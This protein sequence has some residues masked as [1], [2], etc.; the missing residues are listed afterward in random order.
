MPHTTHQLLVFGEILWDMLP[1]GP[2]PGGAPANVA[3]QTHACGV[4]TLLVTAVGDDDPGR[5]M[6]AHLRERD[7]SADGVQIIPGVPTGSVEVTLKGKGMPDYCIHTG[8]AWDQIALTPA[9]RAAAQ[10]ARAI[11]FGSLAQRSPVSRDTLRALLKLAPPGCQRFFDVNL[12]RPWFDLEVIQTSLSHTDILKLNDEELPVIAD[13]LKL[14][15][16]ADAF[17]LAL[18]GKHPVHT[19]LMTMGSRGAA[20]FARDMLHPIH[21]PAAPVEKI[22]DTVGA[23]DAFS[24][25]YLAATLAGRLPESAARSGSA[26]ASRICAVSGAWLPPGELITL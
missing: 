1:S 2:Q 22:A 19:M 18:F 14:P 23:G 8:V 24:A 7:M 12:R 6:L 20:L 13:M 25:G 15:P 4:D 16:D 3:V 26:L 11:C 17:A 10:N 5:R 21:I 9:L